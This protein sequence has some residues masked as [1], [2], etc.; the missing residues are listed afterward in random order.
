VFVDTNE[1]LLPFS[2]FLQHFLVVELGLFDAYAHI[3]LSFLNF[4]YVFYFGNKSSH[5]FVCSQITFERGFY[6]LLFS[7]LGDVQFEQ[8]VLVENLVLQNIVEAVSEV[9]E[10]LLHLV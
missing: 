2:S 3:V 4:P 8:S 5:L 6:L 7:L 10:E 9:Y 1:L